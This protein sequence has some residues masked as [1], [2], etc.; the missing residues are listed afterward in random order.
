MRISW[1]KN[2]VNGSELVWEPGRIANPHIGVFADSGMG[3]TTMLRRIVKAMTE[4]GNARVRFHVFDGHGDVDI[5]NASSVTFHESSDFGFNPLELSADPEFGGVRKRIQSLIMALNQTSVRLGPRQERALTR[6]LVALYRREGFLMDDHT[7]WAA[8]P[9]NGRRYPTLL[10]AIEYGRERIKIVATGSSQRAVNALQDVFKAAKQIRIKEAALSR[11]G[12]DDEV[13][14]KL[15]KELE[16]ARARAIDSFTEAVS[17]A[18]TGDEFDDALDADGQRETLESVI[19]RL[20]NLYQIGIY[21]S[22]PPPLDT[23]ARVW[24]YIIKSLSRDEKK[25]FTLTRL[26]TIFTRAIARGVTSELMDICV[27]DEAHWYIDGSDDSV[28]NRMVR[29]GRKF[30]LCMIFATQAPS[31]FADILMGNLGTKLLLGLDHTN[32]SYVVRKLGFSEAKLK[33][34]VPHRRVLVQM[35]GVGELNA[36]PTLVAV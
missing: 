36:E 22:T 20:E 34:I 32:S 21:R 27:L 19:D 2:L 28:I 5:E 18:Y 29:E 9:A 15:E 24:R 30:G 11:P 14:A 1:G 16:S 35:K 6:L 7:T 25:L 3:K 8:D 13:V 31:D 33:S 23:R 17:T 26:E 4:S 10:D 12:G